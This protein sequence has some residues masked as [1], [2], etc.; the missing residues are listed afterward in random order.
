MWAFGVKLRLPSFSCWLPDANS[1]YQ[2][3]EALEDDDA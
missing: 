1:R 2:A 3:D